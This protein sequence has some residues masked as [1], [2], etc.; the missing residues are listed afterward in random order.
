MTTRI[1]IE[2]DATGATQRLDQFLSAQAVVQAESL[3]RTRI[4]ALIDG[5][6]VTVDGAKATQAKLKIRAGQ[7]IVIEVPD[8]TPA[9]P[10]GEAIALNIVFE[11]DHIVVLDKPAGLVV[12]PG[13]GNETGTL[14]NALIAHCG[15]TLSGIGGV[16]RPGIVHRLDK[17]TSGLLVVAKT[18]AAHHRLSRLF[19]DHGRSLSLTRE[20]LA[21]V[22]GAPDRQSGIVDAPLGRHAIQREKMAVVP[23]ARGREAITHWR[24]IE[25]FSK[26]R[27]GKPIASLIAC[28]LETGRTHQIRVHMAHIGHPLLGDK[29]YGAGFKTKASQLPEAARAALTTLDRQALHAR[30]LGFE[31][32]I[33]GEELLFESEPPEDFANLARALKS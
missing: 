3:S 1:E 32:P 30:A 18:D 9:E 29:T 31:H 24:V 7:I 10:L 8:A 20:Y 16:K 26:D 23:E 6:S 27:D 12:H 11:D 4:Q 28:Q 15:D 22:W 21:L 19:A 17:D 25:T 13:A 5:G 14:V 33:T 2:V